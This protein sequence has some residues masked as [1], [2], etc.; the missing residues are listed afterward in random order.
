MQNRGQA[1]S[2]DPGHRNRL[3]PGKRPFHTIIPAFMTRQ[4]AP[5]LAFGVM[6]GD[7]QPQGHAQVVMNMIDFGLSVQQA[8]DVPRVVHDGSSAPWGGQMTDGGEVVTELGLDPAVL[9][10]LA[11]RGHRIAKASEALGGYQAIWREDQ[12]LRYF[13]GSDPR[14]DGQAIGY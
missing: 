1:F 2:L 14:K 4:G 10:G 3:E 5:V 8:T 13:G 6:G 7:V 9:E 12:P 11:A